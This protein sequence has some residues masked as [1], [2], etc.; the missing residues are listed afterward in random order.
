MRSE[1]GVPHKQDRPRYG[2]RTRRARIAAICE[3]EHFDEFTADPR[4]REAP[5]E[6]G[7]SIYFSSLLERS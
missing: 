6:A 3:D 2:R 4:V 7:R 5:E 1:E